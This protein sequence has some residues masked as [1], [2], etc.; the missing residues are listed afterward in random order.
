MIDLGWSRLGLAGSLAKCAGCNAGCFVSACPRFCFQS[1]W[2][3]GLAWSRS[4]DLSLGLSRSLDLA[5]FLSLDLP[6]DHSLFLDLDLF[7]SLDFDWE[8]AEE[9]GGEKDAD[10]EDA[11]HEDLREG[12]EEVDGSTDGFACVSLS[13]CGRGGG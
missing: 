5:L 1:E 3:L 11:G 12:D 4:L 9:G 2:L 10:E 6:L 8:E 7:R 13:S